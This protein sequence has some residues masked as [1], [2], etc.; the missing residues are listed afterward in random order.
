MNKELIFTMALTLA[1][2]AIISPDYANARTND[3]SFIHIDGNVQFPALKYWSMIRHTFSLHIPKN[4][5]AITQL[6][7]QI[8]D[9]V[10][11]SNDIKDI[12]IVDEKG[13]R[14]NTNISV[15]AKTILLAFPEPLHPNTKFDI[16]LNKIKR[17]NL[18]NGSVYSFSAREIGIDALIPIGAAWFR[19][20]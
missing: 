8:P 17:Q 16:D 19:R 12:N 11:I 15:N 3:G 9:N 1:T 20:Y 18:G 7:I 5:K 4:S 6:L 14:I 2:T 13:H 10:T